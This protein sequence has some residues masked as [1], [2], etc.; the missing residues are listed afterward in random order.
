VLDDGVGGAHASDAVGDQRGDV[1]GVTHVTRVGE[2]IVDR[3]ERGDV[4]AD[5]DE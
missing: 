5:L 3:A 4:S 2:F 1:A